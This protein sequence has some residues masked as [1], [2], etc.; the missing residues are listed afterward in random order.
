[1][2]S[3]FLCSSLGNSLLHS[4]AARSEHGKAPELLLAVGK[5]VSTLS[6]R[7]NTQIHDHALQLLRNLDGTVDLSWKMV[8]VHSMY[9]PTK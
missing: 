4:F 5:Q 1:L 2:P 3:A 9:L 8:A 7:H 6:L